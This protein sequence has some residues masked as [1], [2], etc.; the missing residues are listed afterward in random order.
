MRNRK[1][2]NISLIVILLL[3]VTLSVGFSALQKQ[4][5]VSDINMEVRLQEDVRVSRISL[6][7]SVGDAISNSEDYN[8]AKLYGNVTFP[9]TSSYV[10]YKVDLTNYGNVKSGLLKIDNNTS[11]TTYQI[12][13]SNGSN[14]T[15]DVETQICNGSNCTL[16]STK[17][18]YV[19][20]KPNTSGT[21]NIDLDFD[22]EPYHN[23]TYSYFQDNTSSFKKEI[24]EKD[25]YS[26]TI[27]S[28]PEEVEVS[29]TAQVNYNKNTGELTLS[30]IESD[31]TLSAK[32]LINEVSETSYSGTNPNNYVRFN[33]TL[34]RIITKESVDDGY[35]NTELRTKI[36]S[37]ESIGGNKF[38]D[39]TNDFGNSNLANVL[40]T[41]Y[42]E[43][44]SVDA[45]E[46]IDTALWINDYSNYI[47]IIDGEDYTSNSSWISYQYTLTP[48]SGNSI[49]AVTTS[50]LVA[51]T[52]NNNRD[53]YP[54]VYLKTN[55]L[56]IDGDGTSTNPYI[57][58]L[59]GN[60]LQPNP[61]QI[62]GRTLTVTGSNQELISVTNKVGTPRY[63]TSTSLNESNYTSGSTTI[64]SA[65]SVN[66]YNIYYYIPAGEGYKAK[67]GRVVT[68]INGIRY[69]IA[70]QKGEN[71]S[72]IG[73]ES[74][75]CTTSGTSLTCSV[76]LPS[77]TASSG[78]EN[79]KWN[80]N[81][82]QYNPGSAF[83]LN[84]SNTGLTMTSS[85]TGKT[86]LAT[87]YYYDGTSINNTEVSCTVSG[88][89]TC[90]PIIPSVVTSSKGIYNSTYKGL[91]SA[92][93]TMNNT[94]TLNLSSS[95]NYYAVYSEDVTNYYYNESA[96]ATRTL[97]RNEYFTSSSA[98]AVKLSTSNDTTQNYGTSSGPGNSS[99]IGLST[100]Q[101]VV[102]EYNSVE[103]AA[104]STSK[105]LYTVYQ[106]SVNYLKGIN[107]SSIGSNGDTC[108]IT[109][110]NPSLMY[111]DVNLN[112]NI[113]AVD[114][115]MTARYASGDTSVP[116]LT[117]ENGTCAPALECIVF[118]L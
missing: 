1:Y 63:S 18:I 81:S 106:F 101:D 45:K 107:V 90:S 78:Y 33:N 111:G 62:T 88:G 57:L 118:K 73:K 26:V 39:E 95:G 49:M 94:Q 5:F 115:S 114:S 91:A 108:K 4:L 100:G 51:T 103:L 55:V 3:I 16:G 30:N 68:R 84:S 98:L 113:T 74:D 44:L 11:D 102:V 110:A 6:T 67:S 58:E 17:E 28:K 56:V 50:G 8:K 2:R 59:S 79:G 34:Y 85:V 97:H 66:T 76:T 41:T 71:V 36:I 22:F 43:S 10:L 83:T 37:N 47:G 104:S 31:I 82:N 27:S 46:L 64:P 38:D 72:S 12:C 80:Y 116:K 35:G 99:W 92:I 7:S 29:G 69:T 24:M 61:T 48:G 93:N 70:Y 40:N 54:V 60:G 9:T 89:S 109:S 65:A 14:C 53:T 19:K 112:G 15:S 20:V 86:Y 21:K 23:I 75:S 105:T 52:T 25:T 13:D 96:Y 117:D 32:Y 77:I 42:Y 87:I